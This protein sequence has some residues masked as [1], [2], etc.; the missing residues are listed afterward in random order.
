MTW[1]TIPRMNSGCKPAG[2]VGSDHHTVCAKPEIAAVLSVRSSR[3]S[4]AKP[5]GRMR[6]LFAV[7]HLGS[8]A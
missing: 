3:Q 4:N 2:F 5:G 8:P 7:K 6:K 1:R